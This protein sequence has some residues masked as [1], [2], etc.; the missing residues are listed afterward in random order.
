MM[1]VEP[2]RRLVLYYFSGTGNA[3]TA[4]RWIEGHAR[5]R[6]LDTRVVNVE[7]LTAPVEP[8]LAGKT[9]VGFCYPT[10]GFAP[11]WLMLKFFFRFPTLRGAD[12]FFLN[13][14]GGFR[15]GAFHRGPGLS[16]IAMWLPIVLFLLQG[17]RVVGSLPLDM[18]HSWISFF[19]PNSHQGVQII[20]DRCRR[21]VRG[22]SERVLEG[23]RYFRWSVWLT[24][25]LDL[26]M[27]PV[28]VLYVFLGRFAL[29]K[30]LFAS[31]TCSTCRLCEQH[32]PVGAIE[33]KGGRPYWKLTCESC[34]RCMNLC[35]KK[36]I[37][38]WVTRIA[39]LFYGLM[40]LAMAFVPLDPSLW[41]LI[42][43]VLFI[44]L[45][46]LFHEAW[47]VKAVNVAFTYTS[48]T[49]AW[50]R[51]LAPGV[52][53]IDFARAVPPAVEPPSSPTEAASATPPAPVD[54]AG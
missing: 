51:Y 47:R 26:A 15:V 46:R 25:P 18:P 4:A 6:G 48:L 39:L 34:M 32:C 16:G 1:R 50:G 44:P 9:L 43:T 38:S 30:T 2:Y 13:T 12:L 31:H 33:I 41:M 20:T 19:W 40:A 7:G 21:L 35:P 52:K 5:E 36:S 29:A 22:F 8:M 14:R 10:H 37:Q 54:G 24:L 45:Y 28:T 17:Y 27:V 49:R 3:L 11:P 42:L 23:R 53:A